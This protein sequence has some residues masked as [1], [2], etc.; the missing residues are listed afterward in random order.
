MF[1]IGELQKLKVVKE[2]PHGLFLAAEGKEE[3]KVLLPGAQVKSGTKTG[4]FLDVFLYKDSEDRL[5]ATTKMPLITLGKTARLNV[6]Q[7]NKV[8]AFLDWGLEKDLFLPFREQTKKAVVGE[9]VLVALYVDKSGRLAATMNVYPYLDN[10]APYVEGDDVEGIAYEYS[11]KFGMFV[12]VDEKYSAIIPKREYYGDVHIGDR[13]RARVS[14]VR[15]D[16]RLDLSIRE[17]AYLQMEPDMERILELLDSYQ[18]VLPFTEK[19]DPAVIRRETGMSKSEF[20]RAVGHLYK[21]RKITIT[22]GRIR[23]V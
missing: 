21:E 22:D 9:C 16:G 7:V 18:G 5:I 2:T 10:A 13:I 4:D 8:G 19:A 15:E 11:E 14:R 1:R 3:E 17:K 12:A 20:K 23:R 6:L